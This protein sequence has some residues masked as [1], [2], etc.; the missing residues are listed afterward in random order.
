MKYTIPEVGEIELNKIVLDLN[1]TLAVN[2]S[3]V[4]GVKEKIA[5]LRK[6]GFE[7]TLFTGDQRGNAKDLCED[8]D[9]NLKIAK[10]GQEKREAMK[11]FPKENTVAIGNARI[12]IGTFE[13]ARFSIATLQAEGIHTEILNHVDVIVPSIIDAF[14]LLLDVNRM[15]ATMRR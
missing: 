3:L 6:L 10:T 11:D 9:I 1:G 14:D 4:P 2:G 8:L 12:D 7:M 13:N 5:E 15:A